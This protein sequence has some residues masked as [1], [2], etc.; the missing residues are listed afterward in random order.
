MIV[1]GNDCTV[2]TQFNGRLAG[3]LGFQGSVFVLVIGIALQ[4]GAMFS[5]LLTPYYCCRLFGK[6][7]HRGWRV[8]LCIGAPLG[9]CGLITAL[10]T[11][12]YSIFIGVSFYPLTQQEFEVADCLRIR[13][14][15]IFIFL[16]I[17]H[18][19]SLCIT[20]ALFV[21]CVTFSIYAYIKCTIFGPIYR[22]T[23][24]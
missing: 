1:D 10:P 20:F 8:P 4:L 11:L 14:Y 23:H 9:I 17:T 2:M 21:S 13:Y 18:V 19:V 12:G 22:I 6:C 16:V 24:F 15:S 5:A 7:Q 3:S